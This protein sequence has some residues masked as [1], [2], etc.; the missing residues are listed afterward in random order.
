MSWNLELVSFL[1][2]VSVVKIT[3][4]EFTCIIEWHPD[5]RKINEQQTA[6]GG[7]VRLFIFDVKKYDEENVSSKALYFVVHY[8]KGDTTYV[9]NDE[10]RAKTLFDKIVTGKIK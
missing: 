10:K 4:P 7:V 5:V 8:N 9:Y 3:Y 1:G 2:E 6:L